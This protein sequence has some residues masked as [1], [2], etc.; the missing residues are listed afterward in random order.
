MERKTGD[1]KGKWKEEIP[2]LCNFF[3]TCKALNLKD[4][5]YI[6]KEDHSIMKKSILTFLLAILCL[7]ALACKNAASGSITTDAMPEPDLD[8]AIEFDFNVEIDIDT[9]YKM[10]VTAYNGDENGFIAQNAGNYFYVHDASNTFGRRLYEYDDVFFYGKDITRLEKPIAFTLWDNCEHAYTYSIEKDVKVET[11][12]DANGDPILVLKPILYFY[13]E[14]E[15]VVSAKLELDGRLT[16]TYPEHGK[17]GWQNFVAKP[18]GT[19]IG[20]DGKEYYA[21][22]WE[23]EIDTIYDFSKGFCVE[24]SRT[25][26]FLA[27]ILPKLGLSVREANEFIIYWL[28]QMQNNAYNLISFQEE[29]YTDSAK[30]MLSPEPDTLIRVFMAWKGLKTPIEIEPQTI[31]TPER[32]GFTVVEWGGSN[33]G[34]IQ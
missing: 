9:L 2:N 13:P 3:A 5:F 31:I 18:D 6:P 19:L 17:D 20:P 7:S 33:C 34:E 27:D 1:R 10:R 30:L 22:Y 28:P 12:L 25:A 16:C 29:A 8:A 21:L 14:E 23:G 24:G 26:E 4:R 15:T 11:S 32:V